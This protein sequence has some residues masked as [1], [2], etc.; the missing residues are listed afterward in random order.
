MLAA[1][2]VVGNKIAK[3][4]A[5][6]LVTKYLP[7]PRRSKILWLGLHGFDKVVSKVILGTSGRKGGGWGG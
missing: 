3:A 7:S 4:L 1:S 6:R 2:K 5:V